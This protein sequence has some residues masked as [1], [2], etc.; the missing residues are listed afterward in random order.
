M[1]YKFTPN[2]INQSELIYQQVLPVQQQQDANL[3]NTGQGVPNQEFDSLHINPVSQEPETVLNDELVFSPVKPS[4][5][6]P[7]AAPSSQFYYQSSPKVAEGYGTGGQFYSGLFFQTWHYPASAGPSPMTNPTATAGSSQCSASNPNDLGFVQ[8]AGVITDHTQM[9]VAQN[10][11]PSTNFFSQGYQA[12]S[13]AEYYAPLHGANLLAAHQNR[14]SASTSA[15]SS[16]A[17]TSSRAFSASGNEGSSNSAQNSNG[18]S[19]SSAGVRGDNACSAGGGTNGASRS[20]MRNSA[21]EGRECVNCGA[22]STPLWRRDGTGH[23][24]CNAC[25]LYHK[26]NGQNRPL[27]K[28]KKR[29]SAQKRTGIECVN[30]KTS[31]TTLW[32]R[33]ALGQ[34]VCNACGLYHKLHNIARPISM[35]K[36]GIQTRNRKISTKAK[37]KKRGSTDVPFYDMIKPEPNPYTD[38]VKFHIPP[39]H[40]YIPATTQPP[41]PTQFIFQAS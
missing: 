32:R 6:Y 27:V 12:Y 24:L 2:H 1:E 23:Y 39:T 19:T 20:K 35:K 10:H 8:P 17:S 14:L 4:T 22:V 15:F 30:C 34:P 38:A 21:S 26:M 13:A 29:Q 11:T 16:S 40:A 33:N 31:N 36:E 41:Y 37:G 9:L 5:F 18:V 3:S 28:P 7:S 25:G